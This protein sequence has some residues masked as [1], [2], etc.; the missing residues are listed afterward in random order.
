AHLANQAREVADRLA[1][2][3]AAE[4]EARDALAREAEAERQSAIRLEQAAVDS[5]ELAES[6]EAVR[7]EDLE[8]SILLAM[9]AVAI[10]PT[11]EAEDALRRSLLDEAPPVILQT[12]GERRVEHTAFS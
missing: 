1:A 2:T 11:P 4:Q 3:A 6:A 9:E 8:L 12:P 5:R 10:R 7:A